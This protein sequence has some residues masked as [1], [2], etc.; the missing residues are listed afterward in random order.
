MQK[1]GDEKSLASIQK[2]FSTRFF[3]SKAN[4]FISNNFCKSSCEVSKKIIHKN[5]QIKGKMR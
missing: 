2:G 5:M 4:F 3:R 1:K